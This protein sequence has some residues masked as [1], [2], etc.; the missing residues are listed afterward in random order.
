M[1][2]KPSG[3]EFIAAFSAAY[4]EARALYER[5]EWV[6]LWGKPYNEFW[7]WFMMWKSNRPATCRGRSVLEVSAE[8]LGLE[9]WERE[10]LKLDGAFYREDAQLD[11]DLPFPMV[12]ALEHQ[13]FDI[14]FRHEI[15]KLMSV[16]CPLKVGITYTWDNRGPSFCEH[17]KR[18]EVVRQAVR[19]EYDRIASVVA[20]DPRIEYAFLVGS[21]ESSR[22][23]TWYA[24]AFSAGA[25]P[26][27]G[28][29][30]V[31]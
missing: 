14:N 12:V 11:Y 16:R 8:R 21:E 10:P 15:R 19:A 1:S 7:N 24:L 9:Y 18:R 29:V 23:C 30:P 5:D 27:G 6:K 25:G 4:R 20:E 28:F 31:P 13:N 2:T 3:A 17:E 22:E 26:G